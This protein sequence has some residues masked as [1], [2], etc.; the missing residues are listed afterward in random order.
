[1]SKACF[2]KTLVLGILF[3]SLSTQTFENKTD[4]IDHL[5]RLNIWVAGMPEY[6]LG[7]DGLMT[8]NLE[9]SGKSFSYSFNLQKVTFT[10]STKSK[11]TLVDIE[12]EEGYCI[13]GKEGNAAI[14]AD[15]VSLILKSAFAKGEDLEEYQ[16]QYPEKA[17]ELV[18]AL[19]YLRSFYI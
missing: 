8:V 1:M 4:A 13:Y 7:D 5:N 9:L 3:A 6:V 15:A 2:M 19:E 18:A 11:F 10:T 14:E 17:A 12:C 16:A